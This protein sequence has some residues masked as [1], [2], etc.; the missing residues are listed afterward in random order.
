[1]TKNASLE[2][3][4]ESG[5]IGLEVLHPGG[6]AITGELAGLCLIREGSLVL[7]VASGTGESACFLA[8]KFGCEVTGL[9]SSGYMVEKARG[10]AGARAL[11][12]DFV[13][14]DAHNL[15]FEP[16]CF[17][18]VLSECTICLLDKKRVIGEMVRVSKPGGYVGI[19][20]ICWTE[21]TPDYLKLRLAEIEGE[22]PETLDGWKDLFE[23]AGLTDVITVDKQSLL[24]DWSRAI[25][26]SIGIRGKLRIFLNIFRRWGF[27]G[28]MTVVESERIFRSP[29]AGYGII[30]GRKP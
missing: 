10:K 16:D 15:P 9:D 30:V 21:D 5:E 23:R 6:L 7:D 24:S 4:I 12:V 14:G 11:D 27:N 13:R 18:A 22:R 29:F 3:L 19:H 17:D 8:E 26:R 25:E 28:L 2:S 20:D 1:V